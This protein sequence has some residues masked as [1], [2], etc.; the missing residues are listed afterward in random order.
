MTDKLVIRRI[1]ELI[2]DDGYTSYD[3]LP[4]DLKDELTAISIRSLGRNGYEAIVETDMLND[5]V[6]DLIG[7]LLR[8]TQ[9]SADRLANTLRYNSVR[10]F[11]KSLSETFDECYNDVECDRKREAG[12]HP[13]VDHINGE[14]RWIK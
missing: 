3:K 8:G 7:H 12:L 13:I 11:E 1:F 14:T 2:S 10:Y 4:D 5:V 6:D 9:D